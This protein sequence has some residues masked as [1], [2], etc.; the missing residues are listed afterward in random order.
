MG[1]GEEASFGPFSLSERP[2]LPPRRRAV[3]GALEALLPVHLGRAA[4]AVRRLLRR[5]QPDERPGGPAGADGQVRGGRCRPHHAG[6]QQEGAGPHMGGGGSRGERKKKLGIPCP[7]SPALLS[8]PL[9]PLSLSP[10]QLAHGYSILSMFLQAVPL[11][12]VGYC[13]FGEEAAA[14]RRR[15]GS[16]LRPIEDL[17]HHLKE[18]TMIVTALGRCKKEGTR[19]FAKMVCLSISYVCAVHSTVTTLS[20]YSTRQPT[21]NGL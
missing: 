5:E 14:R 11:F 12:K 10:F 13:L 20:S 17:A 7:K 1:V 16:H 4:P 18:K 19:R 8:S 9:P 21:L 6:V 2:N 15:A 3:R